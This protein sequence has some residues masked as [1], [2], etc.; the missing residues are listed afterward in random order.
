MINRQVGQ[1]FGS[2]IFRFVGSGGMMGA[3]NFTGQP[4]E[5]PS[6]G[7][8]SAVT[9]YAS[10]VVNDNPV[11]YWRLDELYGL[12]A[13][14]VMRNYPAT[15]DNGVVKGKTAL[16]AETDTFAANFDGTDD[17]VNTASS[18]S[19][20]PGNE[21][22]LE[23]W[24]FA[25]SDN[26][27]ACLIVAQYV[28]ANA[29]I[30]YALG[31]S[32]TT[33]ASPTD[34]RLTVGHFTGAGSWVEARDAYDFP[35]GRTIHAVGTKDASGLNVYMNGV[36]VASSATTASVVVAG[37]SPTF[38][39]RR[40]DTGATNDFFDGTLDEAAIYD[41]AL[42]EAEIRKHYAAGLGFTS[43]Q[44]RHRVI[45]DGAIGY[46]RLDETTGTKA[47][48]T[49]NNPSTT[50]ATIMNAPTL[51]VTTSVAYS[52]SAMN[53]NG[54]N[55][56]LI[57]NQNEDALDVTGN[58]TAEVWM[59]VSASVQS[60]SVSKYD[61]PADAG[62]FL[63]HTVA[64]S[65]SFDGRS[66]AATYHSS[67][68]TPPLMGYGYSHVV[69]LRHGNAWKVFG[70]GVFYSH[71]STASTGSLAN[72]EHLEIGRLT[73]T[74]NNYFDGNLDQ[75]AVYA[76]A[77]SST[78]VREHWAAG[79]GITPGSLY[80][81]IIRDGAQQFWPF[82]EATGSTAYTEVGAYLHGD[83]GSGVSTAASTSV[84]GSNGAFDFDGT[85]NAKVSMPTNPAW[86]QNTGNMTAEAWIKTTYN[87]GNSKSIVSK[88]NVSSSLR[89][90]NLD[91]TGATEYPRWMIVKS[92]TVYTVTGASAI[93]NGEWR[94]VVGRNDG[95]N[96][97]IWLD[98][99]RQ[100]SSANGGTM[101]NDDAGIEI[102]HA[103]WAADQTFYAWDG[104]IDA[105]AVYSTALSETAIRTHYAIGK[106]YEEG[107]YQHLAIVDGAANYWPMNE[108]SGTTI[109]SVVG[110][111]KDGQFTNTPT[112][113]S[114]AIFS[115]L[116]D[117]IHFNGT[118]E[119][120]NL[121][122]WGTYTSATYT[123]AVKA[124]ALSSEQ[125]FLALNN[126][127]P[128]IMMRY[129]NA[130]TLGFTMNNTS[131]VSL[132]AGNVEPTDAIMITGTFKLGGMNYM[133]VNGVLVDSASAPGAA[134]QPATFEN[135]IGCSRSNS[136]FFNGYIDN[137]VISDRQITETQVRSQWAALQ[138]YASGTYQHAVIADGATAYWPLVDDNG[139]SDVFK[140]VGHHTGTYVGTVSAEA[141]GITRHHDR[142]VKFTATASSGVKITDREL[143]DKTGNHSFEL[144]YRT[145]AS[146][147]D[148][149]S[150]FAKE[151]AGVTYP[152]W[153]IRS[154]SN[155]HV[156]YALS[157]ANTPGGRHTCST[158]AAYDDN[159]EHHVVCRHDNTA[160][161]M[162][163]FVDGV[164][165]AS[166]TFNGNVFNSSDD[167]TIGYNQGTIG[168]RPF[169][170]YISDVAVYATALSSETIVAH[171]NRGRP[172]Q[173]NDQSQETY[174]STV[175]RRGAQAY[176]RFA[177]TSVGSGF[178]SFVGSPQ[179]FTVVRG[180]TTV[181]AAV[182]GLVT[183]DSTTG[184]IRFKNTA[185]QDTTVALLHNSSFAPSGQAIRS[186]ETWFNVSNTTFNR[187]GVGLWITT[188][189]YCALKCR[190][191]TTNKMVLFSGTG[192]GDIL[193]T[194]GNISASTTHHAVV[195]YDGT[196]TSMYLDGVLADSSTVNPGGMDGAAA[197]E[198]TIGG[199]KDSGSVLKGSM[200]GV[201][202]EIAFYTSVLSPATILDHYQKGST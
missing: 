72:P 134:S 59:E 88:D 58:V 131:A 144:W 62:W 48:S 112:L 69:G 103:N 122:S 129:S 145:T 24:A 76:T 188:S 20:S 135:R 6:A 87:G 19:P 99:V 187:H 197:T 75:V 57:V 108:T 154:K 110:A 192:A 141:S 127:T 14:D 30:P 183:G 173:I 128:Y 156:M 66:G 15:Y 34:R 79:R 176:Y 124:S 36:K 109:K 56:Y 121:F 38:I 5:A 201:L 151:N 189:N 168:T 41:K 196:V 123:I 174:A 143:F 130:S 11:G 147:T 186:F 26:R 202:D 179:T 12:E 9:Q 13:Y 199:F 65:T 55:E 42:T 177:E 39:G 191:G 165:D 78:T 119:R 198:A 33:G 7:A 120:I 53:F 63:I 52:S 40:F 18:A 185:V 70:N 95:T 21:F 169:D 136:L 200:S 133:Y 102:G 160:N 47:S 167:I 51:G 104:Q 113:Q 138:G 194:T 111:G 8:A 158:T 106:G 157:S 116:G 175:K 139:A 166:A 140:P 89:N 184:G 2:N 46:W 74:D 61:S 100:N 150:L 149:E 28:S 84:N 117:S 31:L 25:S 92:N 182:S 43:S 82:D 86:A 3:S 125:R 16:I 163:I 181:S 142:S 152:E 91:M 159:W 153:Q 137:L 118:D 83:I 80:W 73:D 64:G 44:L 193:T 4:N 132:S 146:A 170:G 10:L 195:T 23:T 45:T 67:G 29:P 93:N 90:W 77:L 178:D 68:K 60:V 37:S 22:T 94:H 1:W 50:V 32:H 105:P 115:T 101:D 164:Q 172:L 81:H 126:Q 114:P 148:H 71:S 96:I 85:A 190:D 97:D 161:T 54:T 180:S 17:N 98:G 35:L 155:G 171:Y 49:V 27:G 107:T 162:Q